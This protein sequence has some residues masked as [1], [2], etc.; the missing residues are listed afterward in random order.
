MTPLPP[1]STITN[2]IPPH[3]PECRK[4]TIHINIARNGEHV[5]VILWGDPFPDSDRDGGFNG[6]PSLTLMELKAAIDVLRERWGDNVIAR[7]GTNTSGAAIYPY[8]ERIDQSAEPDMWESVGLE[9]ARAGRQVFALLFENGDDDLQRLG[10]LLTQALSSDEQIIRVQS[11]DLFVPWSMLYTP[12]DPDVNLEESAAPWSPDGFWGYRHLIE[13]TVSRAPGFDARIRPGGDGL[14][15]GMIIDRGLDKQFKQPC[16]APLIEFFQ[17]RTTVIFRES[18]EELATQ[19]VQQ[20]V[21]DQISYFCCH[22]SF[23]GQ[24]QARIT[25]GD[26]KHILTVDFTQWIGNKNLVSC[27]IVF[28]NACQGGKLA[29]LFYTSFGMTL[30]EAG[31]NCLIGPQ[32]EVPPLFAKVYALEFF[33]RFLE[34]KRIGDVVRDLAREFIDIHK[35]PLGLAISLYRGL[36]THIDPASLR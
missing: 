27:P 4:R 3:Y 25:L 22:G 8:S 26:G 23:N 31:A 10:W 34:G 24:Q 12:S 32:I 18:R 9:L 21:K 33:T 16:I 20:Q 15:T 19:L 1:I 36:D 28:V 13:H 5:K 11:D 35:N 30:L 29:S 7:P 2:R 17:D 6:Q 14:I